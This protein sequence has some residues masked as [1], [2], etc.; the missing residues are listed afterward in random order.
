MKSRYF[1]LVLGLFVAVVI[2]SNVVAAAKV[3]NL[4]GFV[5]GSSAIFF[6]L[7]YLLGD[8][9]TEVYG[10]AYARRLVWAGTLAM[11][12][13]CLTTTIV[14]ALPPDPSWTGQPSYDFVF[15]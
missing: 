3:V 2:L 6:P 13:T 11:L 8:V 4:H 7:S 1:D 12:F 10:Y 9:V 5:F 14:V 15:G